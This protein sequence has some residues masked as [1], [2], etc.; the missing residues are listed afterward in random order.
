VFCIFDRNGHESFG[1]ARE[2]IRTLA[3]RKRNPI[4][5]QEVISIPCFEFWVLLHFEQTDAP[6]SCCDDVIQR[7]RAHHMANY[8]KADGAVARQLM[9]KVLTAVANADWL[10]GRA[11]HND[12]NPYTSVHKLLQHL[13]SVAGE[14]G[15][16]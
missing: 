3:G 10:E 6:F 15:A 1:R 8:Q 11:E 16:P 12:Q 13:A 2:R 14:K 7:I 4:S 9:E 5:I